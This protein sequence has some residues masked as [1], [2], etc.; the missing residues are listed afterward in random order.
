MNPYKNYICLVCGRFLILKDENPQ[1]DFCK[2][3]N[4]FFRSPEVQQAFSEKTDSLSPL[5]FQENLKLEPRDKFYIDL[6]AGNKEKQK[7]KK[8]TP[9]TKNSS[10]KNIS[11]TTPSLIKPSLTCVPSGNT[12]TP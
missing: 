1:C 8:N 10:I 11:T 12:K 5:E 3:P 6:Y 7:E 2:S 4:L 9:Y